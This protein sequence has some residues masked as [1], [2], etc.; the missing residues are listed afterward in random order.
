MLDVFEG[1]IVKQDPF[2]FEETDPEKS[3]A[4]DSSLWEVIAMKNHYSPSV[5]TLANIFDFPVRSSI[6]RALA[7]PLSDLTPISGRM[8]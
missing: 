7:A 4:L 6:T 8:Q 1:D 3:G 2:N 5:A